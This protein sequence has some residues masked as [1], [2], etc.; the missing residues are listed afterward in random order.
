MSHRFIY[1]GT[2]SAELY[3]NHNIIR[4]WG[5]EYYHHNKVASSINFCKMHEKN[6]FCV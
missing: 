2:T 1:L 3:H 5:D 4:S 6:M